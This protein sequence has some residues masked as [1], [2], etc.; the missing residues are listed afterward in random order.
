MKLL[1]RSMAAGLLA[2]LSQGILAKY[3]PT[4][5]MITGSVGKTSTKDAIAA[6]LGGTF[7]LRAS[8]KSY[9]SEFGVPLTIIGAKNPWDDAGAWIATI[10]QALGLILLPH[11]YPR[12]LVL[13]VGADRPGD[14]W[15]ILKIASPDAVVVTRLP[16]IPVHVELYPSAEAVREEEFAPAYALFE[17]APLV[18][19]ADD[20]NAVRLASGLSVEL[21]SFGT[22]DDAD[23]RIQNVGIHI[24]ERMPC[25]VRADLVVEGKAYPLIV[26]G[27]LGRSQV[28]APAAAVATALSLGISIKDA[29]RGLASYVPPP[30]RARILKGLRGALII[31][32]SYNASPAAVEEIVTSLPKAPHKGR[33]IVVLGD[34]LE[35]GRYSSDEHARIGKL[36]AKH[37]DVAVSVGAR[38]LP[39]SQAAQ[40]AGIPVMR[41]HT[42]EEAAPV[43]AEYLREGDIVLVKGSQSI[44]T[45]RIV[46]AL[47]A[48]P[49]DAK[50]LVRQEQQWLKRS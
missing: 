17:G 39:F 12:L 6:A 33:R 46:K 21:R 27:A 3:R 15:R 8:E 31:D 18:V 42:S 4:V 35:L 20:H 49:N 9:N 10:V 41:F 28:F 50:H 14:L 19:L 5:L 36:A 11:D 32:D 2:L 43:L 16:D 38:A 48:D 24:E 34:M 45:E 1:L 40:Q 26:R 25:G 23:V 7:H 37:A 29:M 30:G 44:R 13:E 22:T 47:L